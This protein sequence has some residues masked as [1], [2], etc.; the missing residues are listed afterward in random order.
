[1]PPRLSFEVSGLTSALKDRQ[2]AMIQQIN[3]VVRKAK[4]ESSQLVIPRF[5][6]LSQ[7][8]LVTYSDASFGNIEG[9]KSQGGYI[10]YLTD[11]EQSFPFAW[12]SQRVKRVTKSTHAAETLA[13][14]DAAEAAVYY[15]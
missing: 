6:N 4:K 3:K 5:P 11:G 9:T 8:R 1:M 14:V 13:M 10:I 12:Q 7:C 2:V 15:R